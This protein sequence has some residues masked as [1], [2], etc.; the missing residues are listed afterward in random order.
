LLENNHNR[1]DEIDWLSQTS[2][3]ANSDPSSSRKWAWPD[4][5]RGEVAAL[6]RP[7]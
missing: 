4:P 3:R 6:R 5:A 7:R 1:H 2:S